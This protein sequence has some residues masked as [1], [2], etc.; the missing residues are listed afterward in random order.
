VLLFSKNALPAVSVY[1]DTDAIGVWPGDGTEF[2]FKR[3]GAVSR[4]DA[5]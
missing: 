1:P 4:G 3:S 5:V 2:Y